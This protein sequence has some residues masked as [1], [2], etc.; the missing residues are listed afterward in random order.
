MILAGETTFDMRDFGM[1]PPR[2]LML[3]VEPDVTVRV[4]IVAEKEED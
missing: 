2:I 4:T 1:E 3:R